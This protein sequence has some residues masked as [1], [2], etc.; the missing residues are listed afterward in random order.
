M[1]VGDFIIDV[2]IKIYILDN[3]KRDFATD[4]MN[5]VFPY[6]DSLIISEGYMK[7][8]LQIDGCVYKHTKPITL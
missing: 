1:H 3:S 6:T 7:N 8:H 5:L 4:Y 2:M